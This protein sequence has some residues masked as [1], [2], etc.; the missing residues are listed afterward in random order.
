MAGCSHTAE[1]ADTEFKKNTLPC[2][3]HEGASSQESQMSGK[4]ALYSFA[5]EPPCD[6]ASRPSF[7]CGVFLAARHTLK[8]LC[9]IVIHDTF[10]EN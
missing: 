7:L 4:V 5:L 3:A 1:M 8:F 10:R 6:A 2:R 9:H